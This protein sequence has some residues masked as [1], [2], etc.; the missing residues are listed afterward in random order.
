MVL[1]KIK[2]YRREIVFILI[3]LAFLANAILWIDLFPDD[4]ELL[5]P[6]F[7]TQVSITIWICLLTTIFVLFLFFQMT[8][9]ELETELGSL[10]GSALFIPLFIISFA[11][12][13]Y[14]GD[15]CFSA[16][17]TDAICQLSNASES[18]YF[19]VVTFTTLGYGDALPYADARIFAALEAI[20][21]FIFIPVLISQFINLARDY[22]LRRYGKIG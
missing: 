8:A 20:I 16:T 9:T 18:V 4:N 6:I 14:M 13:Y 3:A 7:E 21:G 2:Q 5:D 22:K 19:S 11:Y 12:R 10:L 1:E 17:E 15:V